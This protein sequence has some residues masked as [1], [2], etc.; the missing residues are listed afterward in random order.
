MKKEKKIRLTAETKA[1][2]ATIAKALKEMYRSTARYSPNLI[3]VKRV[4]SIVHS[5][6][7]QISVLSKATIP[8]NRVQYARK[9]EEISRI[10][11]IKRLITLFV[12]LDIP[13]INEYIIVTSLKGNLNNYLS[14][15]FQYC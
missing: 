5:N 9:K 13:N 15:N 6:V 3:K 11:S 4:I 1:P 12:D 2:P 7:I 8:P 14:Y 10:I